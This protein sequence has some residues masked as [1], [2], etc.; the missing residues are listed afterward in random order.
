MPGKRINAHNKIS[1]DLEKKKKKGEKAVFKSKLKQLFLGVAKIIPK[2][3]KKKQ[4]FKKGL[5]LILIGLAIVAFPFVTQ[6]IDK[7]KINAL[8]KPSPEIKTEEKKPTI[9]DKEPIKVSKELTKTIDTVGEEIPVR[10]IIPKLAID[11]PV[12]ESKVIDGY[13]EL[14]DDKASFGLGSAFPGDLGNSVIF[15]HAREKLFGPLKRISLK[16]NIYILTKKHYF[17]YEVTE[18]KAVYPNQIEVVAPTQ[19]ERLTLFTCS[20]FLDNQRL[21]VIAKRI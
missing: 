2:N 9:S 14:S 13:W 4:T 19:D 8:P 20:G 5:S 15:A 10:I 21:V 17:S 11:I 3:K 12:A 6:N 1:K 16:D 7:I 18:V